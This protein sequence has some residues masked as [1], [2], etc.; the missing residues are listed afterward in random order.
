MP[1]TCACGQRFSLEHALTCRQGRYIAMRHDEV[2]DLFAALLSETLTF[3]QSIWARGH[4]TGLG[5]TF[6]L[7][8]RQSMARDRG[9][10]NFSK[11]DDFA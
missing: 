4:L 7:R 8:D 11:D 3:S 2:R 5:V 10:S 1:T 9:D 6:A